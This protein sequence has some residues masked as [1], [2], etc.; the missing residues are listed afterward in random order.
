MWALV[1]PEQIPGN[2]GTFTIS[3]S[4]DTEP[5]V[6]VRVRVWDDADA[7]GTVPDNCDFA[8]EFLIDYVP[9][10][11]Q[12]VIDGDSI[13][14]FCGG[15]AVPQDSSSDVRGAFGGPIQRPVVRCNRRYLVLVQWMDTFP[16]SAPGYFLVADPTGT[17][18]L[19]LDVT[20]R[21]G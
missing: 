7:D 2:E 5:V 19:D 16:R 17:L 9:E 21:E 8:Y 3:I 20:I 11:S 4:T 13:T 6:G 10:Q 1:G 14:T 12:M 15:L 18:T